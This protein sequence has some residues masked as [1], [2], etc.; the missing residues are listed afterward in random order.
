MTKSSHKTSKQLRNYIHFTKRCE[1][2]ANSLI[3]GNKSFGR[4]DKKSNLNWRPKYYVRLSLVSVHEVKKLHP[5]K[6]AQS[7]DAPNVLKENADIFADFISGFFNESIKNFKFPSILKSV[8]VTPVFT[9]GY[10]GSKE[11][12]CPV[13]TL[14]VISKI[15]EKIL[16]KQLLYRSKSLK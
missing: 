11:N 2:F 10:Q 14:P 9:K 16:C 3:Q 7:T 5:Q 8:N 4:A 15:F 6:V 1:K 13:S 12:F